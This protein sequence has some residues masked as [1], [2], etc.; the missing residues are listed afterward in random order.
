MRATLTLRQ[1]VPHVRPP[2]HV[3]PLTAR[4][5]RLSQFTSLWKLARAEGPELEQAAPETST[6]DVRE[7][8]QQEPGQPAPEDLTHD[9][10]HTRPHVQPLTARPRRLPQYASLWRPAERVESPES[11]HAALET[12]THD[13]LGKG[14]KALLRASRSAV[15]SSDARER[16]IRRM[17]DYLAFA[18]SLRAEDPKRK[19]ARRR[20]EEKKE[21]RARLWRTY[22]LAK[23]VDATILSALSP[24]DWH[25][26]W[27]S[28]SIQAQQS[29]YAK[30]EVEELYRTMLS[31]GVAATSEQKIGYLKSI[32]MKGR[33]KETLDKWTELGGPESCQ[34]DAS[35]FECGIWLH[36]YA[37]ELP[38]AMEMLEM[39]SAIHPKWDQGITVAVF[40]AHCLSSRAEDHDIAWSL[41]TRMKPSW[42]GGAVLQQYDSCFIGFLEAR[43]Y[44]YA[45]QVFVDCVRAGHLAAD[46]SREEVEKVLKCLYHLYPLAKEPEALTRLCTLSIAVLPKEYSEHVFEHWL[47]WTAALERP[48]DALDVL[49]AMFKRGCKPSVLHFNLVLGALLRQGDESHKLKG[50][51]I[52][53]QMIEAVERPGTVSVPGQGGALL[54]FPPANTATFALLMNHH[55]MHNQWEHVDYLIRQFRDL[56]LH[57]NE[58]ILNVLM[59]S[60]CRKGNYSGTWEIFNELVHHPK[61]GNPVFPNGATY[62]CLW[63][64]LR[65]A[66]QPPVSENLTF[67]PTP[68]ALL[69]EMVQWFAKVRSRYDADAFRKGLAGREGLALCKLVLHPFGY[70]KDLPGSLVALHVLWNYFDLPPPVEAVD[71]IKRQ[72]AWVDFRIEPQPVTSVKHQSRKHSYERKLDSLGQVFRMIVEAR[73]ERL[74]IVPEDLGEKEMCEFMLQCLSEFVRVLLVRQYEPE[75]VEEMIEQAK[76]DVGLPD[77]PTGDVTAFD[78]A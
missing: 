33:E 30:T 15:G 55:A 6:P 65:L 40:R 39:L 70:A 19:L 41:Y 31:A 7:E 63:K 13:V 64:T 44:R 66:L 2:P 61:R 3:Q 17:N 51:N 26:L 74:G 49:D 53:W 4:S 5:R 28:A 29:Q 37:G 48:D 9:A 10:H 71:I 76:R 68:R 69:A 43:H 45:E 20:R 62:R 1:K 27:T 59:D 34:A 77:L 72:I 60:E 56:E 57:P 36:A 78:V 24:L 18:A 11:E 67:L 42:S 52:G 47:R 32:F 12:S 54:R 75:V 38:R 73:F 50:E 46:A 22:S 35:L 14:K 16:A 23:S 21:L 58:L 8:G 25:L